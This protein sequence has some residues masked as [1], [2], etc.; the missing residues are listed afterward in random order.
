M[1]KVERVPLRLVEVAHI[2]KVEEVQ[3]VLFAWEEEGD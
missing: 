3:R 2:F 1:V